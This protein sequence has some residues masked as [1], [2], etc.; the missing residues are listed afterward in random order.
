MSETQPIRVFIGYDFAIGG[1]LPDFL[2]SVSESPPLGFTIRWTGA[3]N[4]RSQGDIWRDI[5]QP[6]I[7]ECDRFLAFL[8][9][10]NIN[11]GFEI[12][13]ALGKGKQVAVGRMGLEV[14]AWVREPP[15]AG[16]MCPRLHSVTSMRQAIVAANDWVLLDKKPESGSDVL[17]LCPKVAGEP[18]LQRVPTAGGWREPPSNGWNLHAL[19]DQLTGIGLVLWVITPHH[20]GPQHRDGQENA[21]LSVIAGYAASNPKIVLRTLVH[22]NARQPADLLGKS[23]PFSDLA[24]FG[25]LARNV[26]EDWRAKAAQHASASDNLGDEVSV[27]SNIREPSQASRSSFVAGLATRRILLAAAIVVVVVSA[28]WLALGDP[29][30]GIAPVPRQTPPGIVDAGSDAGQP[31]PST[32]DAGIP[33]RPPRWLRDFKSLDKNVVTKLHVP[34]KGSLSLEAGNMYVY[35][36]CDIHGNINFLPAADGKPA[37]AG[38]VCWRSLILAGKINAQ[39]ASSGIRQEEVQVPTTTIT[40]PAPVPVATGGDG[41]KGGPGQ[42]QI[43]TRYGWKDLKGPRIPGNGGKQLSGNGGGGGAGAPGTWAGG[44]LN[45]L[46]PEDHGSDATSHVGGTG[47]RGHLGVRASIG[48]R[49]GTDGAVGSDGYGSREDKEGWQAGGSGGGGGGGGRHGYDLLLI[50]LGRMEFKVGSSINLSGGNGGMGGKGGN[51]TASPDNFMRCSGGGG[52]GGGGA[53][54]N[55]GRLF[56][57]MQGPMPKLLPVS[58]SG[59]RG[60][61]GG[62]GGSRGHKS[63]CD[64]KNGEDGAKG[65]D[66][67]EGSFTVINH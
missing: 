32:V 43:A 12:G 39:A 16:V 62:R 28:M 4:G 18:Y 41:G 25:S 47:A 19:S 23:T 51:G 52:G 27:V 3:P 49:R 14:P 11:V 65:D 45:Q 31:P 37:V 24:S 29:P 21:A 58:V 55:G 5:V 8:D 15:L 9:L 7:E 38:L 42:E 26:V 17:V 67:L 56:L 66:G 2:T 6:G 1:A 36:D 64:G 44:E 59:G 22:S 48:G 34:A 33:I 13:Y 20:D 54:G 35:R 10:P 53:G 63:N 40:L 46:F 50:S 60:G 61:Q 30:K 57:Y